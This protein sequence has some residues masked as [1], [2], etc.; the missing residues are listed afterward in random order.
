[1]FLTSLLRPEK[2]RLLK[3]GITSSAFKLSF[4]ELS[5]SINCF[6]FTEF[7]T[8][9]HDS[10]SN[11]DSLEKNSKARLRRSLENVID[12]L[13]IS[14]EKIYFAS[15]VKTFSSDVESRTIS[16][17]CNMDWPCAVGT[18]SLYLAGERPAKGRAYNAP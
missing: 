16:I 7:V 11:R 5:L 9:Y 13:S 17:C 2:D 4:L 12:S 14:L 10:D 15:E 8:L 18:H 6:L 1:M 3:T